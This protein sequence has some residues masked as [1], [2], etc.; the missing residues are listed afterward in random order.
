M[1]EATTKKAKILI[2][3]DQEQNVILLEGM[4]RQEGYTNLTSTNESSRVASLCWRTNFDLVLLD[5]HMPDPDGFEVMKMLAPWT[6]NRWLP[7]LVLT[8]DATPEVRDRALAVGAKDFVTKPFQR[9]EVLLRIRNLLEV[10][11]LHL[12][13]RGESLALEQRVHEQT[14]DLNEAR[15]EVLERL[16]VAAEYRDDET[17]EHTRR[18]GRTSA[19]I[20]RALGLGDNRVE[21][22]RQAA[23]LH[24]VG[25]I[26]VS[27][28]ILLKPGKLTTE[29]FTLMKTH[30][31]IGGSILSR[32]RSL[33]LQMA[34]Q[35][36]CTHHEWWDGSGYMC[37]L[38]GTAIPIV[39]RIVAVAD[40]FDALTHE[41]PYKEAWPLERAVAEILNL[42][43]RQF[44]P[45]VVEAFLTLDHV[46]LVSGFE[47][48][49]A[50]PSKV[51]KS[52][53][54]AGL[55]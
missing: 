53:A 40:V 15:L 9:N 47:H 11:F 8:A 14:Q 35:I 48:R 45:Q 21:L 27:D 46:E 17:G 42:S 6:E 24:D 2:V 49:P 7:I 28:R 54:L 26:G 36:A 51:S 23:P 29:E 25:K 4:L 39:G 10:R 16:A 41:R 1:D 12:E 43:D 38:R 32:S 20:A 3:D 50:P 19:L 55:S 22:I 5:L 18:V 34:E 31:T 30:V 33:L 44:D 52:P 37:G 13:L